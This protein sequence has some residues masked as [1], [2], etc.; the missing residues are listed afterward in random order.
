MP[1]SS[2]ASGH[3]FIEK[4]NNIL[5]YVLTKQDKSDIIKPYKGGGDMEEAII[6]ISLVTA[7]INLITAILLY[8]AS[9]K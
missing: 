9:K 2:N 8:K 3:I 7:V 5:I 4:Y 1:W 6:V